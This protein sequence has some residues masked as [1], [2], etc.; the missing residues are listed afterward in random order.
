MGNESS[1]MGIV[2]GY[3]A[4]ATNYASAV[5]YVALLTRIIPLD[6][7][8]YYNALLSIMSTLGLLFPTLGIDVAIAREGAMTHARGYGTET[9][10]SAVLLI[11]LTLSAA[12][13]AA[14]IIAMPLYIINRIPQY[15]LGI[16]YLYVAF[17]MIQGLNNSL[18]TYL[19][20]TGRLGTQGLGSLIGNIVFR[21]TEIILLV[22][23][24]SV[25]AI[26]ISMVL[27]QTLMLTYYLTRIRRLPNPLMGLVLLRNFRK[28]LSLGFQN[29]LINYLSSVGS[30]VL[31]YLVYLTLGANYVA[32]YGIALY[33]LGA[34]TALGSSVNNVFGSRLSHALGLG[35]EEVGLVRD[36]ASSS[37]IISGILAQV[38]ALAL[39]ILPMIGII[40]SNYVAA[41]PYGAALLGTATL[42]APL[43]IYITYHWI[44][45]KGWLSIRTSALGLVVNIISFTILV[46]YIGMYALVISSYLGLLASLLYIRKPPSD[47]SLAIISILAIAASLTYTLWPTSQLIL[48]A[49]TIVLMYIMKPLPRSITSQL[50]KFAE[51]LLKYFTRHDIPPS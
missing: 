50:P 8:G 22:L 24:K 36:Y 15:Y 12:Y 4:A 43:S 34:V 13:S 48:L 49:A 40:G 6:Q 47:P 20:M 5:I 3:L 23:L 17:I 42:S 1:V 37:A 33:I 41:I 10:F 9:Y 16:P 2:L 11:S 45:N 27:G 32:L 28:Y 21:V 30:T 51:P 7:Y 29:W 44:T 19:W 26:V 14:L 35:F 38:A 46:Q 31:T 25:Y 39:P 18:S